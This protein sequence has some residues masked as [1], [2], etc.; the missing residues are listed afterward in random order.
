[1]NLIDKYFPVLDKGFVCLKDVM[2]DDSS[3]VQA[4][5]T[6]YG[7][8]TKTVSDDRG[9]IRYLMRHRHTTPFEMVEL[10]FFVKVPMD[11][12]RQW[13][14]HRMSSVNEYSTRYSEAIDDKQETP[15]DE[16]RLQ[17]KSNKQGSSGFLTTEVPESHKGFDV[18]DEFGGD[19]GQYLSHREKCFH[20]DAKSLYEERLQF[21]IAKEQARK[22]LPLSTYTIAYWK[23]D[24]H[25]LFHFLRLR[26]DSH[27]QLEIRSY[28]NVIAGMVKEVC[29]LAFEAWYDYSF[30]SS[31]WTRLDKMLL[32]YLLMEACQ[33]RLGER[34]ATPEQLKW[35]YNKGPKSYWEKGA[36]QMT[37][38]EDEYHTQIGMSKRELEEFWTK[39]EVPQLTD[40]SL[41]IEDAKDANYF[42]KLTETPKPI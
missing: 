32:N 8:G 42:E 19:P 21:G 17:S 2:G 31:N 10:K 1:M 20:E 18:L 23:I 26:C 9:L 12:W 27:A 37:Y 22:D 28:A 5:R 33:Y 35:L 41:K 4:A 16:W 24:L 25:N 7:K 36:N 15:Q 6:S 38:V 39:L 11:C 14:R 40:F 3:I 29:P 13:I 34:S 30:A